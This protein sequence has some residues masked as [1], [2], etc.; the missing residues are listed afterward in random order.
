[1]GQTLT[2]FVYFCPFLNTMTSIVQN[3]NLNGRSIDSVL[4]IQTRDY[5]MVGAGESTELWRTP[6]TICLDLIK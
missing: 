1:M 5:R 2:L 6:K 3:L 4:W